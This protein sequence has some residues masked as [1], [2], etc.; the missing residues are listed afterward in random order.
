[1][2]KIML[3]SI[4]FFIHLIGTSQKNKNNLGAE[5]KIP[6]ISERWTFSQGAVD[7]VQHCS[8]QSMRILKTTDQTVLKDFNFT[9]GTI[10]YDVESEDKSFAHIYK[11]ERKTNPSISWI[12][13]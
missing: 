4:L 7:F 8:I 3:S 1:M 9:D 12:G 5:I 2:Q 6:M 11:T 13:C 10:E